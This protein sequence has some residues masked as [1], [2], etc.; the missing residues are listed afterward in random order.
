MGA[1]IVSEIDFFFTTVFLSLDKQFTRLRSIK[2]KE[3]TSDVISK[4]LMFN[5]H[6]RPIDKAKILPYDVK[7][8]RVTPIFKN[9]ETDNLGNYRPIS[10]LGSIARVF[11]IYFTNNYIIFWLKIKYSIPNN[12]IPLL[13]LNSFGTY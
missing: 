5:Y 4:G 6:E 8:A 1:E 11:E 12:G 13:A 9:G 7:I 2:I 10:I 3:Q